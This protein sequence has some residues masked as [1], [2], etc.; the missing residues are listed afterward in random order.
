MRI[1]L[2]GTYGHRKGF[3]ANHFLDMYGS[4]YEITAYKG[5]IR[6]SE[7][8]QLGDFDMVLHLAALAGVRKSHEE[9]EEY[10]HTNV[11]ASQYFFDACKKQN[12]PIIYASSSSVYDWW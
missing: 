6:D 11:I 12:V 3:I 5:D 8:I 1:L 2:T 10:W 4:E 7:N 9:P